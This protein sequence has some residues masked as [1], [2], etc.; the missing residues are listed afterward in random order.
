MR[1][2]AAAAP[3]ADLTPD[4][5]LD[6]LDSVGI[7]GDGRMLALNSYENRVYQVW[8]DD[9]PVVVAKFYR[10]GRWRDEQIVERRRL[11][12]EHAHADRHRSV[13]H[14]PRR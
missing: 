8:Q 10:P 1:G 13:L 4:R 14:Q 11:E 6:A 5:I 3:Y 2:M 9:G 12:Q 7:A